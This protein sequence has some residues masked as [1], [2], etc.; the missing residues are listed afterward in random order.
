MALWHN[1]PEDEPEEDDDLIE[2][3]PDV[4]RSD[5]DNDDNDDDDDD[6]GDDARYEAQFHNLPPP[7]PD[8]DHNQD[9]CFRDA[10]EEGGYMFDNPFFDAEFYGASSRIVISPLPD[11]RNLE[12]AQ[13]STQYILPVL[14]KGRVNW[15]GGTGS[16]YEIEVPN[17]HLPRSLEASGSYNTGSVCI[18]TSNP[19]F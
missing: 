16:V 15:K 7:G 1:W 19:I 3:E 4:P 12:N 13:Q 9:E 14:S 18:L 8:T 6:D 2:A 17:T 10:L 11:H 5:D